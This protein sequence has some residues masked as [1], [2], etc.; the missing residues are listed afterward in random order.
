MI[1]LSG[2]GE[3]GRKRSRRKS[4]RS[5]RTCVRA[6]ALV[7][8]FAATSA[9]GAI[10]TT[11][12]RGEI[13]SDLDAMISTTDAI[14]GLIATELSGD[15][16]WHPANPAEGNSLHPNGLPTF[17]DGVGGFASL[18]GLLN[19]FP[20]VGAPA[21]AIQYD[22][23]APTNIGSIQILTGNR[24]NADGR[25]F[26]T[27]V[28]R[29]STN[30][31]AT[32]QPLG[33]LV[34]TFEGAEVP[35]SFGYYQSDPSGVINNE[36]GIPGTTED[37]ANLVTVFDDAAPTLVAGVT[38]LQFDFYSVDNTMGEMRD[39]FD[40]VNPFTGFD[41]GLTAAFVSPLVWEIDVIPST[42][43]PVNADFNDDGLV[44]G[45]DYLAWQR[46]YPVNDG[47]ALPMDGDANDDGNVDAE[48]LA[49]WQTQYGTGSAPAST[50]VA[51][52]PEPAAVGLALCAAA[53]LAGRWG[54]R[55]RQGRRRPVD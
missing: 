26:S 46:S 33:G 2:G 45:R 32:F 50:A 9:R 47:T 17:T 54:R 14:Q 38:N 25:I 11:S 44:D 52:V 24:S 34:R 30:N 37:Q 13:Y 49:A 36:S 40:G 23:A 51:A 35:N 10:T 31:G 27:F 15:Q 5:W 8:T 43:A 28:I 16:G 42:A 55:R 18:A 48:D 1:D 12:V 6:A 19:D 53:T 22:L 7:A 21:K 4:T 3:S 20:G 39:P 41:D 29:Y